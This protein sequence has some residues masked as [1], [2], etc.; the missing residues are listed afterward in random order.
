MKKDR[1]ICLVIMFTLGVMVKMS[2][3]GSLFVFPADDSKK[4]VTVWAKYLST[5]E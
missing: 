2:K 3:N 4:S 1:V 5:S